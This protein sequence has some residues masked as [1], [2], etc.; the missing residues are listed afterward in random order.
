[1][2][3]TMLKMTVDI[4]TDELLYMKKIRACTRSILSRI[5][6][7]SPEILWELPR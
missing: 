2:T 4:I 5:K 6:L 1:M 7:W 3:G